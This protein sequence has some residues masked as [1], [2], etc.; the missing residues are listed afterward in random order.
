MIHIELIP[1]Q[2]EALEKARR[3]RSTNLAE[4]C[5][6]ILL[7]DRGQRVHAIAEFMGRHEH[8]IRSWLK[9]YLQEGIDG[10][11][12]T[13]PV[14]RTNHKEQTA[15]TLLQ[16]V[17]AQ[18]PSEYGYLEAGWSTNLLVDYLHRQGLETSESTVKRALKRGGWV[19]KRFAKTMP[20]HAPSSE[21]KKVGWTRLSAP[22]SRSGMS[23][24]SRFILLMNRTLAMSPMCNAV[25]CGRK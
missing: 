3:I 15:L 14:G 5:L 1:E 24:T 21:E 16:P 13:P 20:A 4:R 6:A 11:K 8:T 23:R 25:G 19:Y 17:L 12:A 2:R 18:H 9:A 22:S 10:L 7:S